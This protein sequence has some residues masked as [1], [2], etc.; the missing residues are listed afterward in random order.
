MAI[1]KSAVVALTSTSAAAGSTKASPGATGSWLDVTG[2]YGGDLSWRLINGGSAPGVAP[3][4]TIQASPD[5]GTTVFDYASV[6]GDI[7]A[8]SDNSG[9][10][11][12]DQGIQYVRVIA[13]GNTTNAITASA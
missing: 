11:W 6:G 1:T 10:I 8:S 5:N 4:L 2:A 7:I 3:T 12:I 13:Y 9:T